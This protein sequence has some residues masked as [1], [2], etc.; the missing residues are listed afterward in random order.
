MILQIIQKY[1]NYEFDLYYIFDMDSD[2]L[3]KSPIVID[4]VIN[5]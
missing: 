4:N 2:S 5:G 3:L 1:T